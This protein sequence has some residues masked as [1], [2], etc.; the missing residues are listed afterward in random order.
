LDVLDRLT[1]LHS[2]SVVVGIL[3]SHIPDLNPYVAMLTSGH[4][5]AVTS[6]V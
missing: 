4:V 2:N 1:N 5:A 3:H 6:A